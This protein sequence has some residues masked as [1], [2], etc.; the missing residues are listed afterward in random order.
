MQT[1][2]AYFMVKVDIK[3]ATEAREQNNNTTSRSR[4][5]RTQLSFVNTTKPRSICRTVYNCVLWISKPVRMLFLVFLFSLSPFSYIQKF[6]TGEM[7]E[8]IGSNQPFVSLYCSVYLRRSSAKL[9]TFPFNVKF[10]LTSA[11]KII[12]GLCVYKRKFLPCC[13]VLVLLQRQLS[14]D[15]HCIIFDNVYFLRC[16]ILFVNNSI[17]RS[18]FVREGD[19]Y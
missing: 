10:D 14:L 13:P 12:I 19:W 16:E 6:K 18:S 4:L 8:V 1:F 7:W 3:Y 5:D 17:T 2:Q 15:L 9:L 11:S